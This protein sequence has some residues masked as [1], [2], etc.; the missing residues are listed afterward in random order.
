MLAPG[1]LLFRPSPALTA[2]TRAEPGV[3]LWDV[4]G[5]AVPGWGGRESLTVTT[6][7]RFCGAVTQWCAVHAAR[8]EGTRSSLVWVPLPAVRQPSSSL[9]CCHLKPSRNPELLMTD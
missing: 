4:P 5:P 3:R 1:C 9:T 6:L 7:A 2:V 8:G